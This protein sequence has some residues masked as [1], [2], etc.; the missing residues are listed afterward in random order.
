MR[1]MIVIL[2]INNILCFCFSQRAVKNPDKPINKMHGRV[3]ELKEILKIDDKPDTYYFRRPHNLK[4]DSMENIYIID[5]KQFL[6]FNK[7]GEFVQNLFKYGQGP[8]EVVFIENYQLIENETI[9]FNSYPPKIL[10][11]DKNGQLLNEKRIDF[12]GSLN[13]LFYHQGKFIFKNRNIPGIKKD[14]AEI[15]AI[16]K[17]ISF[18]RDGQ[19]LD[20]NIYSFN[21]KILLVKFSADNFAISEMSNFLVCENDN[22]SFY[23]SN[24][25]EYEVKL[26]DLEKQ[27]VIQAIK[28]PYRRVKILKG[29]EKYVI[30]DR[31]FYRGKWVSP[32]LPEYFD[33]IIRIFK[34]KDN[35][36][37]ITSTVDKQKGILVDVFD[38]KGSYNDNFHL[39]LPKHI[40]P[41]S[42]ILTPLSI[43]ENCLYIISRDEQQYYIILKYMLE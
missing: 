43:S 22:K 42:L 12:N 23:F 6:K 19:L 17:I 30:R 14:M 2:L 21:S 24:T 4:V 40:E 41:Y 29:Q 10:W 33:D 31:V 28:R 38:R 9:I 37:I 27:Q 7:E 1:R 16:D 8:G 15:D 35:L 18:S 13:F 32:P 34:V 36:W 11:L 5:S 25:P 26:F 39:K 3:V 20:N